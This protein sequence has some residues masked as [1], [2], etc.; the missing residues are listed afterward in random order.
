MRMDNYIEIK[1]YPFEEI[2]E[3]IAEI[4]D[5]NNIE[6]RIEDTSLGFDV[7]F[8]NARIV[9][10]IVKVKESDFEKAEKLL[11]ELEIDIPLEDFDYEDDEESKNELLP[12]ENNIEIAKEI[13]TIFPKRAKPALLIVGYLTSLAGGW[14]GAII[15]LSILFGKE[16]INGHKVNSYDDYSKKHAKIMMGI[17][18]A[19]LIALIIYWIIEI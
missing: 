15:A 5:E 2:V 14:L 13:K 17:F 9:E 12:D 6:Y 10:Y 16:K 7:T 19:W 18:V 3:Q 8:T 1:R 4:L 11:N